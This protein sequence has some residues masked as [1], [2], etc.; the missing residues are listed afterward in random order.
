MIAPSN[1]NTPT[2]LTH[3]HTSVHTS[4]FIKFKKSFHVTWCIEKQTRKS[5]TFNAEPKIRHNFIFEGGK[6]HWTVN[7]TGTQSFITLLFYLLA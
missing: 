6:R 2:P 3:K 5:K 7:E 4:K 1:K